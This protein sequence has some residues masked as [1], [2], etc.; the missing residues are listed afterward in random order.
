MNV[1]DVMSRHVRTCRTTDS[2]N[3]AAQ[4]MWES[5]CGAVPV[6]DSEGRVSAMVT[7]RDICMAAYTQGQNLSGISVTTASSSKVVSVRE[8]ESVATAQALMAKYHVRRL[9]VVDPV[10]GKL[11][12]IVTLSDLAKAANKGDARRGALSPGE[13]VSTM[14]AVCCRTENHKPTAAQAEQSV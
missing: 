7:D 10:S 2:L 1:S 13:L 4:A 6:L 5:D 12:G 14:V 9:P 8:D 3:V 11:S